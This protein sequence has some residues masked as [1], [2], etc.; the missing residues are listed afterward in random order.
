MANDLYRTFRYYKISNGVRDYNTWLY[1]FT[2]LCQVLHLFLII[3]EQFW[4]II[5]YLEIVIRNGN[6]NKCNLCIIYDGTK[7][8]SEPLM[9]YVTDLLLMSENIWIYQLNYLLNK[10]W[11]STR[12]DFSYNPNDKSNH[13]TC[14]K[15][16]TKFHSCHYLKYMYLVFTPFQIVFQVS[17]KIHF[18]AIKK[19][20]TKKTGSVKIYLV[21]LFILIRTF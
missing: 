17:N 18:I 14:C 9:I 7:E 8:F 3:F 20:Q 5:M 15:C 1:T 11:F 13:L 2:T 21:I 16:K 4:L 12:N 6:C 19:K 10:H